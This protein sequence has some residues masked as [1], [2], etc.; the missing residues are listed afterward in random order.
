MGLWLSLFGNEGNYLSYDIQSV[1]SSAPL[2]YRIHIDGNWTVTNSTYEWCTGAGT[3]G[4]P[5]VIQDIEIDANGQYGI[6]I[7]NTTEYFRIENVTIY[8]AGSTADSSSL[9]MKNVDNG[10]LISNEISDNAYYGIYIYDCNDF[11]VEYNTLEDNGNTGIY[12]GG[13]AAVRNSNFKIQHNIIRGNNQYGIYL[14]DSD[15]CD[16][17]NNTFSGIGGQNYGL[18]IGHSDY[19][20][21]LENKI[22]YHNS[23]GIYLLVDYR[24]NV[25][26]NEITNNGN[27]V[28][29]LLSQN[30][31]ILYN[32]VTD[33][34]GNGIYFSA[35][36][37]M[38]VE[39]NRI[40]NNQKGFGVGINSDYNTITNNIIQDNTQYGIYIPYNSNYNNTHFQFYKNT[41]KSNSIHALDNS[42]DTN[43]NNSQ[44]GNFWDTFS[45]TDADLDGIADSPYVIDANITDYRP[46]MVANFS[47]LDDNDLDG[48]SDYAEINGGL[49]P[50]GGQPTNPFNPDTDG[51]G[52]TDGGEITGSA[53]AYDGTPTNPNKIDTDGD[54]YTDYDEISG[55]A[56]TYDGSP[57][58]PNKVDSDGD[59][60]HDNDEIPLGFNPVDPWDYPKPDLVILNNYSLDGD[61]IS[62]TIKNIGVW[63]ATGIVV[64]VTI[65]AESLVLYNNEL[66]PFDLEVNETKEIR[67]LKSLYRHDLTVGEN[68]FLSIFVDPILTV[69]ETDE[70]NNSKEDILY[71]HSLTSSGLTGWQFGLII[72][73]SIIFVATAVVG[74]YLLVKQK[75]QLKEFRPL[76]LMVLEKQG[77]LLLFTHKFTKNDVSLTSEQ[78]SDEKIEKYMKKTSLDVEEDQIVEEEDQKELNKVTKKTTKKPI[79]EKSKTEIDEVLA[80]GAFSGIQSLLKSILQTEKGINEISHGEYTIYF[81]YDEKIICVLITYGKHHRILSTLKLFSSSFEEIFKN[82]LVEFDGR[83]DIFSRAYQIVKKCFP[84]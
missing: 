63:R 12:L 71:T 1:K 40:N 56:N 19:N 39:G 76:Q 74:T 25:T 53:N 47:L 37:I 62:F 58:D 17:W 80:A 46:L 44:F 42:I 32:N 79:N 49:N 59:G 48:L 45:G 51:D 28:Y 10:H 75:K 72:A 11:I 57:I 18:C 2:G 65:P 8:N 34:S 52:L 5:Y 22:T 13:T 77:S 26:Q 84:H 61:V 35:C 7:G 15:F 27:G 55:S 21:V 20:T 68:Y 81:N 82:E 70:G 36:D 38:W 43:W 29:G 4:N 30:S 9:V 54:G 78:D 64:V 6:L 33:N 67:I 16:F 23:H 66:T 41:F 14:D 24:T 83:V 3:I 73:S 50:F 60:I 31:Y 69:N